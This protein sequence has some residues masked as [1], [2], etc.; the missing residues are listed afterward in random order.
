MHTH[1]CAPRGTVHSSF[2]HSCSHVWPWHKHTLAAASCWSPEL[3][4]A[5]G[6]LLASGCICTPTCSMAATSCWFVTASCNGSSAR[7]ACT[8]RAQPYS[9][10]QVRSTRH[11]ASMPTLSTFTSA[12]KQHSW[13]AWMPYHC[14]CEGNS[15]ELEWLNRGWPAE[16]RTLEDRLNHSPFLAYSTEEDLP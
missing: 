11:Q 15:S 10:P 5:M 1:K 12:C 2:W 3:L 14:L 13:K 8:K 4:A 7:A 6:K 16:F 9:D